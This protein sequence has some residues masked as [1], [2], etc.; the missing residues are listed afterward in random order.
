VLRSGRDYGWY[1][2]WCAYTALVHWDII[3]KHLKPLQLPSRPLRPRCPC[4]GLLLPTW[5]VA[6]LSCLL[7][8]ITFSHEY[9]L[10]PTSTYCF[11]RVPCFLLREH[12]TYSYLLDSAA[13]SKKHLSQRILWEMDST[14]TDSKPAMES[15]VRTIGSSN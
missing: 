12:A 7:P 3:I 10:P 1:P 14:F 4:L 15:R 8:W 13:Y 2:T 5:T 6:R 9:L 11:P